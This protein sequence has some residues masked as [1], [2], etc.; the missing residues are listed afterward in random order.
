MSIDRYYH[1]PK[2]AL[3]QVT[4]HRYNFRVPAV[5][6]CYTLLI[7]NVLIFTVSLLFSE[8]HLDRK[9][10]EMSTM[11]TADD[12]CELT[13]TFP[14]TKLPED[15]VRTSGSESSFLIPSAAN[16]GFVRSSLARDYLHEIVTTGEFHCVHVHQ[17][18]Y[19]YT[20][21]HVAK[22]SAGLDRI[23]LSVLGERVDVHSD[24]VPKLLGVKY[25][26]SISDR[27]GNYV[28]PR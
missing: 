23:S 19:V 3:S 24:V 27:A 20:K 1:L 12:V 21:R 17:L 10:L 26:R 5:I 11:L 7:N 4:A 15:L 9:S 16:D 6:S 14:P 28:I 22:S 13:V 18:T 25:F 2:Y 8:S